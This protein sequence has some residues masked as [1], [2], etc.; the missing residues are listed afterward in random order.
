MSETRAENSQPHRPRPLTTLRQAVL[1]TVPA[2]LL[3]SGGVSDAFAGGGTLGR[4]WPVATR[5]SI[6]QIDHSALDALLKKYVDVDGF[7]DYSAWQAARGD[8]QALLTYLGSLGRADPQSKASHEAKLAFWINAY[9][10]LTIE[11]ILRE[12]PTTSIRNHTAKV[13]G[14]NIWHDL[15]LIVGS[16]TYSLDR[17]EHQILRKMGE[18][19][20]HFTIV[21]ASIGCPRLR[22]EAYTTTRLTEQLADNARDF[23]SRRQNL[24][25]DTRSRTL[26]VSS[27]L[28]WFGEDFGRSTSRQLAAIKPYFPETAQQVLDQGEVQVRYLD[29][30]WRLNDQRSRR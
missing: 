14:Y 23:F 24:R 1:V 26:Y 9:N 10:A 11:G 2:C 3:L 4:K 8:R 21:C 29:Y 13:F 16:E 30:N 17:I 5:S 6:D 25:V 19:R 22:N 20:I 28:D 15:V 18:P 27:I 7:V 12:Y